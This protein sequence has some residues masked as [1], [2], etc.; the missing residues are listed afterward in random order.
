MRFPDVGIHDIALFVLIPLVMAG[1]LV[2]SQQAM[3]DGVQGYTN[4]L[5]DYTKTTCVPVDSSSDTFTLLVLSNEPI[6][7]IKDQRRPG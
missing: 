3:C 5:V 4:M 7:S 2:V 1:Q 6:L